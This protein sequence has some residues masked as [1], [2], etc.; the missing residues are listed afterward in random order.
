MAVCAT[1]RVRHA[2]YT[3]AQYQALRRAENAADDERAAA[4]REAAVKREEVAEGRCWRRMLS[5]KRTRP[6]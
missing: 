6:T 4:R 1:C 2:P 3:C 5:R